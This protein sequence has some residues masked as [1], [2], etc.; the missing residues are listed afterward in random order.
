M[1]R[2]SSASTFLGATQEGKILGRMPILG[3]SSFFWVALLL[4]EIFEVFNIL[5][6]REVFEVFNILL[7]NEVFD[8]VSLSE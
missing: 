4:S 7:L 2:K 1:I 8:I 3:L 5:L 6:L